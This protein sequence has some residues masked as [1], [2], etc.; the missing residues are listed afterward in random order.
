MTQAP[1]VHLLPKTPKGR[2]VVME[3]GG[4]ILP[5]EPT[6]RLWEFGK[7]PEAFIQSYMPQNVNQSLERNNQFVYNSRK[8]TTQSN[9]YNYQFGNVEVEGVRDVMGFLDGLRSLPSRASQ[10]MSVDRNRK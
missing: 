9:T 6:K 3:K 4:S 5:A 1:K 2:Y 8:E 10:F 7:N